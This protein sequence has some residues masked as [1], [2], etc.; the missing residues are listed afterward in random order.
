MGQV[1]HQK[2]VEVAVREWC[3]VLVEL[4]GK[5]WDEWASSGHVFVRPE[6]R[7]AAMHIENAV[8]ATMK[9]IF[10]APQAVATPENTQ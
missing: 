8:G 1:A 9:A 5:T 10:A 4:D 6:T 7:L 2:R 3:L